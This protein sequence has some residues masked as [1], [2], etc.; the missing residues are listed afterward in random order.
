[1]YKIRAGTSLDIDQLIAINQQLNE[2]GWPDE[3]FYR[4]FEI[5]TPIWVAEDNCGQICGY[6]VATFL[7]EDVKIV[8]LT[9]AKDYR[10][11]GVGRQLLQHVLFEAKKFDVWFAM[12]E[13]R[14]NNSNAIKLYQSLGFKIL[15]IREEYYCH[16]PIQDA[17]LMQLDLRKF[18]GK[19]LPQAI[20]NL[21]NNYK[22]SQ[23]LAS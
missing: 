23:L 6:I 3:Q 5:G 1:M 2:Y 10:R 8:N 9:V 13:V 11:Q 4:I 18:A 22:T 14:V 7:S 21:Y 17:Y 16:L 12:L 19:V 15:C 20:P